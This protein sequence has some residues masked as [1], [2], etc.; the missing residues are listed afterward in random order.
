MT[1]NLYVDVLDY[2][3]RNPVAQGIM[4]EEGY[5]YTFYNQLK[6]SAYINERFVFGGSVYDVIYMKPIFLE[7]L[8]DNI[9]VVNIKNPY[10]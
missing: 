3:R 2:Y 10:G 7:S 8:W 4:N 9:E 5:Q 6:D 1:R